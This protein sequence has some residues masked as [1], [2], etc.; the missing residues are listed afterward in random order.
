MPA[1][2][3]AVEMGT[4]KII[5]LVGEI[6]EDGRVA[7]IGVGE[8]SSSGIKKGEVVSLKNASSCLRSALVVAEES[9]HITL[10]SVYH[11]A[12]NSHFLASGQVLSYEEAVH[13]FVLKAF[14]KL[15]YVFRKF[16]Q[17]NYLQVYVSSPLFNF[18][19]LTFLTFLFFFK[20]T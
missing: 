6:R 9:A 20:S 4:S 19:K 13:Y 12:P 14:T 2:I 18:N 15:L 1:P 16:S 17:L 5:V 8:S 10:R 7:I 11:I 3:V